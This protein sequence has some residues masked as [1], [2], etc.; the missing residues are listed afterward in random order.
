MNTPVFLSPIS[1][2]HIWRARSIITDRNFN[3]LLCTEKKNNKDVY[4]KLTD[5]KSLRAINIL[6]NMFCGMNS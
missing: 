6:E 3:K 2:Y 5:N 1:I 4:T